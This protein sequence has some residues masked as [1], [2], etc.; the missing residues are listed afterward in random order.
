MSNTTEQSLDISSPGKALRD[1]PHRQLTDGGDFL[2][3]GLGDPLTY[4][5]M[6]RRGFFDLFT[7]D[8]HGV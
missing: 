3:V 8:A 1:V 4:G 5:W 7:E 6:I 2:I